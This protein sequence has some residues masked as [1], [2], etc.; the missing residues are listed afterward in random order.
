MSVIRMRACG[1]A[2]VLAIGFAVWPIDARAQQAAEPGPSDL[3]VCRTGAI[4]LEPDANVDVAEFVRRLHGTWQ[5]KTRTIQGITIETDSRFYFDLDLGGAST[6]GV[7]GTA[8]MI[9]R[10][11]LSVMDPLGACKACAAD[12]SLGALWKV[13]VDAPEGRRQV[14]LKMDG[15]Y[16]GSYGDFRK[17]LKA[18]EQTTFFRHGDTYLA[19]SL[20][21]PAGGQGMPDDVWERIGLTAD[22]LIYVSCRGGFID[23]FEKLADD[24]P[25]VA[26]ASLA[27]AWARVKRDGSLLRPP[28]VGSRRP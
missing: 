15:E 11:N 7:S 17:G 22:T 27:D 9:D 19:G 23:R 2:A 4:T 13:R 20:T 3:S 26:G 1:L 6:G 12:A 18:T 24:K 28:H 14:S 5:L 8:L 16:L 10:G 21:S 25:L